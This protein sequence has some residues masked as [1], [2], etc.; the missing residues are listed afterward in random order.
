MAM[1]TASGHGG[2]ST[3][4]ARASEGALG[5]ANRGQALAHRLS[6]LRRREEAE[7]G[8]LRVEVREWME[9][10]V[11]LE[12]DAAKYVRARLA[13]PNQAA[14]AG[15][16]AQDLYAAISKARGAFE[17]SDLHL[18]VPAERLRAKRTGGRVLTALLGTLDVRMK[19]GK[20]R[21]ELK[22]EYY[23][24]RDS[25]ASVFIGMPLAVLTTL[26]FHTGGKI[27]PFVHLLVQVYQLWLLYFY[28]ASS[29]RESILAANGSDITPWWIWHHTLATATSLVSLSMPTTDSQLC[30]DFIIGGCQWAVL[31]G[32]VMFVQNTY[33]RKRLYTR[34]ALGNAGRM[35]VA[36]GEM[37]VASQGGNAPSRARFN[38]D[39]SMPEV[40]DAS[41]ALEHWAKHGTV[42]TPRS[43]GAAPEKDPGLLT[44]LIPL[45]FL[46]DAFQFFIGMR[47]A[48]L[49]VPPST[50]ARFPPLGAIAAFM[51]NLIGVPRI[52]G[53]AET[54][55]LEWEA[56]ACSV[57]FCFM[58]LGN[59]HATLAAVT[60]KQKNAARQLRRKQS[61]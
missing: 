45:L 26:A 11:Q 28:V 23:R 60:R 30:F 31:Q 17:A 13:D 41:A 56:V 14:E 3:Y 34:I 39:P 21:L 47:I 55:R 57:A 1:A 9:S 40:K 16:E 4:V 50:R 36:G 29:L 54:D 38:R 46:M 25:A 6:E 43:S 2:Q 10:L 24:F 52:P 58:A 35:S 32:L 49:A 18:I 19:D 27:T 42:L 8:A 44:V 59:A 37:A 12:H 15:R 53:G 5:L 48:I 7:E 61:M 51:P 20:S 33:Q 22:Y